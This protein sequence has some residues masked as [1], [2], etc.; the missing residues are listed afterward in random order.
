[1][2]EKIF[3]CGPGG[4]L[5]GV[6]TEPDVARAPPDAPA[7]L[8]WNVGLNHRVGP[9]RV[10]VELARRLAEAGFTVLRL[11]LSGLGDSEVRKDAVD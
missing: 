11:D 2:S 7:V 5:V 6:L 9:F 8:L 4:A 10:F 3:T 1:V